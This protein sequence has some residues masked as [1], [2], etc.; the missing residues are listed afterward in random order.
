VLKDQAQQWAAFTL[1]L[2]VNVLAVLA[3]P[4]ALAHAQQTEQYF[5][6]QQ[7]SP[8]PDGCGTTGP[9]SGT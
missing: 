4:V 7:I 1:L 5:A 8:P 9:R 2:L 3:I 6:E